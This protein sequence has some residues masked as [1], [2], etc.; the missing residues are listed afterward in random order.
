MRLLNFMKK[1][2]QRKSE[3]LTQQFKLLNGY[4]AVFSSYTGGLYE[5]ELTR[6]AI[7]TIAIHCSKL[8][9]VI[10]GKKNTK[11][12]AILQTKPNYLMTT[13]QFLG[14]LITIL[15]CENNAFIIPIYSD[16]TATDIVGLYPISA[17]GSQIISENGKTYLKYQLDGKYKAIEYER[18]GH[19]RRHY[20]SK[21]FYGDSNKALSPTLDLLNTQVQGIIEGIKQ[22]ATIRF[23]ARMANVLLPGDM[24]KER[25]S[26]TQNNLGSD[27]NG[28]VAIFDS[29]Y[30]DVKVVDS[31]PFIIDDKQSALIKANVMDYFHVSEEV[32]QNKASEDQWNAFYEGCIEPIAIQLGQVLTSMLFNVEEIKRGYQVTLESTKLQFASNTTKLNVSQQLFDRGILRINQVM[33]IWNLPHVPEEEDKRYIRKEYTEVTNLDKEIV[34]GNTDA[35]KDSGNSDVETDTGKQDDKE[36][37]T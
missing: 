20:Y 19:L 16:D 15:M 18:V 33:D 3:I 29:K 24:K 23:L 27:N 35:K 36:N 4:N 28:G 11:L 37:Q 30:A 22:S 32:L 5:M 31:K 2:E 7:E 14:K 13:Q 34:G 26:F 10:T 9:P 1:P 21:D 8:N 6:A 12:N 25:D 17:S